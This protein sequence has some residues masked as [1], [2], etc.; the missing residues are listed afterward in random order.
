MDFRGRAGWARRAGSRHSASV[1]AV[2][3]QSARA[4][5]LSDLSC[6]FQPARK[7]MHLTARWTIP[8]QP[9]DEFILLEMPDSA[10]RVQTMP[11]TRR[12]RAIVRAGH[13]ARPQRTGRRH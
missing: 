11:T 10:W 4:A 3:L 12:G 9:G 2:S 8:Q 6:E 7:G 13:A 5:G 1:G